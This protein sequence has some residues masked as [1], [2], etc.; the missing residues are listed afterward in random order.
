MERTLSPCTKASILVLTKSFPSIPSFLLLIIYIHTYTYTL[1]LQG[2][3]HRVSAQYDPE[4]A[5]GKSTFLSDVWGDG[6]LRILGQLHDDKSETTATG[7]DWGLTATLRGEDYVAVTRAKNGKEVGLS[8]NQRLAPGS[9]L[10]LGGE[11]FFNLRHL[12]T[13]ARPVGSEGSGPN[14]GKPLEWAIGGAYD[15]GAYKTAVHL[16]TTGSFTNIVS[17]HHLAR[18]SDRSSLAAKFMCTPATGSSMVSI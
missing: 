2:G 7:P 9:P 10:T 1:F 3:K 18:V 15:T 4:N 5:V 8:Y 16:A 11:M 6:R 14:A 17:L 13:S 12:R